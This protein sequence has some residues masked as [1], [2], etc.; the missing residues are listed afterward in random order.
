[1]A[2]PLQLEIRKLNIEDEGLPPIIKF[3]LDA[4]FR[5]QGFTASGMTGR[6]A[7][8]AKKGSYWPLNIDCSTKGASAKV[9]GLLD[10][11]NSPPPAK[12]SIELKI[13]DI[14]G[15]EKLMGK[16]LGLPLR[17]A[18]AATV[19]SSDGRYSIEPLKSTIGDKRGFRKPRHPYRRKKAGRES[20]S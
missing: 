12:G 2:E 10:W 18:L 1:M 8:I 9:E 5:G 7:S 16:S 11:G 19:K 15:F 4:V 20:E 13:D 17:L 6:I 3:K 14:A